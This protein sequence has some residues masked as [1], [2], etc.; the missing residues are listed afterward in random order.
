MVYGAIDLHLRYSWIRVI[1]EHG[2]VLRHARVV[3]SAERL[4]A[5]FAG[6]GAIR[7]LLES[8]TE[9]E[10]VA[11]T[12]EGT[13]AEVIV[14]DPN[15]APMYGERHRK[16]KTDERDVIALAE[17]NRRGWYRAADR[18]WA[19]RRAGRERCLGS[20]DCGC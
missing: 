12:L 16:V 8:G 20:A 1:D 13:G 15:F 10:W 14:A 18:G 9:S 17:A 5:A 11:Q 4:V 2:H 3:T 7:I 6:V 19:G